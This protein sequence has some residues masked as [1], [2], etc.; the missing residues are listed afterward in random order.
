MVQK[1]GKIYYKIIFRNEKRR[2]IRLKKR[3]L[4]TKNQFFIFYCPQIPYRNS[5]LSE[6][7]E[8]LW[9]YIKNNNDPINIAVYTDIPNLPHFSSKQ[10]YEK[11][12]NIFESI[13]QKGYLEKGYILGGS[14]NLIFYRLRREQE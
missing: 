5:E 6:E 11:L 7:E 4:L 14:I 1:N 3:E 12:K 9:K 13:Y 8:N 10:K 2:I